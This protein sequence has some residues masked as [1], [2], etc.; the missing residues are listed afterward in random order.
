MKHHLIYEHPDINKRLVQIKRRTFYFCARTYA[1]FKWLVWTAKES[2]LFSLNLFH[3]LSLTNDNFQLN[4]FTEK[5]ISSATAQPKWDFKQV[6]LMRFVQCHSTEIASSRRFRSEICSPSLSEWKTGKREL[7]MRE[8][9]NGR[10]KSV[11]YFFIASG[12]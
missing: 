10:K 11:L 7:R 5:T 6:W 3:L 1:S 12:V 9:K 4:W 8:V 2:H